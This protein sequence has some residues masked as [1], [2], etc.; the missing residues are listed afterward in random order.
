MGTAV[1]VVTI[2]LPVV[3]VLGIFLHGQ[4]D[5]IQKYRGIDFVLR[6]D[7]DMYIGA[8]VVI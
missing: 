5:G 4:M 1:S 8:M 6:V 7:K 3:A 2:N